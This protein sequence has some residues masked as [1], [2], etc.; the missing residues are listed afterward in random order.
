MTTKVLAARFG[1]SVKAVRDWVRK[2]WI[3][4]MNPGDG[5]G[6]KWYFD[7]DVCDVRLAVHSVYPV[8]HDKHTPSDDPEA[9]ARHYEQR[10]DSQL[11]AARV[12][13][14][15]LADEARAAHAEDEARHRR[16]AQGRRR[17]PSMVVGR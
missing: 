12:E 6:K 9:I 3:A 13:T 8:H 4:P 16:L 11:E 1:R 2:G 7:A 10:K 5:Q 15:R 17:Y 14:K